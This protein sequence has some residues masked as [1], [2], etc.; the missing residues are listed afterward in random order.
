MPRP[1]VEYIEACSSAEAYDTFLELGPMLDTDIDTLMKEK[2]SDHKEIEKGIVSWV[3]DMSEGNPK[4]IIELCHS[5]EE[6][7]IYE[8]VDG[9]FKLKR[10]RTVHEVKLNSRLRHMVLQEFSALPLHDQLIAKMASVYTKEFSED[11]L[12]GHVAQHQKDHS[13]TPIHLKK[14]I[15]NLIKTDIFSAVN[16]PAWMES[17]SKTG[18]SQHSQ[19]LEYRSKLM[20]KAVS[21]LL[22]E[23]HMTSVARSVNSITHA[24]RISAFWLQRAVDHEKDSGMGNTLVADFLTSVP[25]YRRESMDA[26]D[27]EGLTSGST[28]GSLG[29]MKRN[30]SDL[31]NLLEDA[32]GEDD[33][34][35]DEERNS[36]KSSGGRAT[37][38]TEKLLFDTVD[39]D[40]ERIADEKRKKEEE[41]EKK[42]KEEKKKESTVVV[43]T[44]EGKD[45][46]FYDDGVDRRGIKRNV[47]GFE[48]PH[49]LEGAE[50]WNIDGAEVDLSAKYKLGGQMWY[51]QSRAVEHSKK[52][53][54]IPGI[55]MNDKA[56][57]S[58]RLFGDGSGG[59]GGGE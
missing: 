30:N 23:S 36:G 1:G 14:C 43:E 2:L 52:G 57:D 50:L 11:M 12:M 51:L 44:E 17:M 56:R 4:I 16:Q 40:N 10:G 6:S 31:A 3:S 32:A 25:K 20:Q 59:D 29:T 58:G 46:S 34:D 41:E 42:E 8:V 21:E 45:E 53:E 19:A 5:I 22:L 18:G 35:D 55:P 48:E 24:R 15:G 13:D 27:L 37:L 49:S 28:S 47:N 38:F 33:D 9:H 7:K 54:P 39:M 26:D